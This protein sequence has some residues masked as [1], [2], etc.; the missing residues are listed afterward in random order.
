MVVLLGAGSLGEQPDYVNEEPLYV[1]RVYSIARNF[2]VLI[3]RCASLDKQCTTTCICHV[4]SL[5]RLNSSLA[6]YHKVKESVLRETN[7]WNSAYSP[8]LRT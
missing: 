1:Q 6:V 7:L 3:P 8:S 4:T 2:F 5:S